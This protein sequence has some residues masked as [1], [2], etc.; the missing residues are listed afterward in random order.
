M[1]QTLARIKQSGKNFEIM[2][3]LDR[4]LMFKKGESNSVD[5]LEMDKIFH[6]SKRGLSASTSDLKEAFGTEDVNE[7]SGKIVKNGEVLLT[8]EH[9]DAEQDKKFKQVI[10]FLTNNASN[11]QTGSPFTAER[12]RSALEEANVNIKN[13]PIENQIQDIVAELS[14]IVP[15]KIETKKIKITIPASYTGQTYGMINQYKE[16]EEWLENGDLEAVLSIPSGMIMDFY[17][18]LNS[19]THGAAL[20]EEIKDE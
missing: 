3:D 7:V 14:K 11:P 8:Q 15:I 1:T 20:S 2:V 17:D 6:D 10:D 5:F 9:R 4:A 19:L 18:K 13:V 12:L 16:R